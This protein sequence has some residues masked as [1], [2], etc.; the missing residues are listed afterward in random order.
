MNL[1][2]RITLCLKS[3]NRGTRNTK[4]ISL[5]SIWVTRS[6]TFFCDLPCSAQ[7][8]EM[9]LGG[10]VTCSPTYVIL[11]PAAVA[12]AKPMSASGC[13]GSNL[14]NSIVLDKVITDPTLRNSK[15]GMFS[16]GLT[17]Q[18]KSQDPEVCLKSGGAESQPPF[19][20]RVS[21]LC[22][23][24][25]PPCSHIMEQSLHSDVRTKLSS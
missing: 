18:I 10:H 23:G 7:P 20:P 12:E 3:E 5:G 17:D 15:A 22:S 4:C 16:V 8:Y 9:W 19:F 24:P 11:I 1:T 6:R 14:P 21:N 2:S 13:L 25:G